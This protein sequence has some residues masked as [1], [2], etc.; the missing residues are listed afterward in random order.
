M[1]FNFLLKMKYTARCKI[2]KVWVKDIGLFALSPVFGCGLM[3]DLT[4]IYSEE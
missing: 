3:T 2:S 1:F 4:D